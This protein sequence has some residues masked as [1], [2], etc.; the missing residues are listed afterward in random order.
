MARHIQV[1]EQ[2][3]KSWKAQM[4]VGGLIALAGFGVLGWQL[5]ERMRETANLTPESP[6][7]PLS[8]R[9][10]LIGGVGIAILAVGIVWHLAARLGAWWHHG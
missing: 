1:I 4:F 7:P 8:Q 6:M 9:M 3:G 5:V 2:T 10:Q